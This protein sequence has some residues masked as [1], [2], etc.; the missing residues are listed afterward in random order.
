MK[1]NFLDLKRQ[2]M[3]IQNN[4]DSKIS[5]CLASS[6]FIEGP[7]VREFEAE[8]TKY[9]NVKH[10]ITCANGTEALVLALRACR[11]NPGDEVITTPFSFFAT[12]EAISS[13]GAK[14]VFVDIN[15][16]DLNID[17]SKIEEKITK[18]TKAI[19]PVHIFGTP[20]DM[21]A[22][23]AIAKK[24]GLSVI[25][26]ACQAIGSEYKGHKVGSL[27]DAACF[28]FYPTKN[29]G[30][31]GDAGMI[32]TNDDDIATVCRA[33]KAHAGGKTGAA[34]F[35]I[36]NGKEATMSDVGQA[37]DPLY[38]PYKYYNFL[39]AMNSR[40]DSLQAAILLAKLPHLD[41]YNNKR[42]L[43]AS[44][45]NA[46]LS[47]T[48]LKLPVYNYKFGTCCWHQYAVLAPDKDA[49]ISHLSKNGIG[50][51]AFYPVPLHLQ[52]VYEGQFAQGECPVAEEVCTQS[53][54]LPIYP[55]LTAEEQQYVIDTIIGYYIK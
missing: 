33:L 6:A 5:E 36:V 23:N 50:S 35:R 15:P 43:I 26:D 28:S 11:I 30:A 41:E 42:A 3:A 16:D 2:Y 7:M 4:I 32:T 39:I 45:Y 27:S 38:D 37:S 10:A 14:P 54:C 9:H 8:M 21:D 29:L 48:P 40:L 17:A 1:V 25:E 20:A 31:F 44:R 55:E 12:T 46:K 19:L 13:I 51:G 24:H 52:K 53:V 49:L 18:K 47:G 34:A 22:I